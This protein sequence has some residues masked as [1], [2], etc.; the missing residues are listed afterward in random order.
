MRARLLQSNRSASRLSKE[1]KDGSNSGSGKKRTG[2][3]HAVRGEPILLVMDATER[4][5]YWEHRSER[6]D[7]QLSGLNHELEA[8]KKRLKELEAIQSQVSP[9]DQPHVQREIERTQREIRRSID[10]SA[11]LRTHLQVYDDKEPGE[12]TSAFRSIN[13]AIDN[14][15]RDMVEDMAKLRPDNKGPPV[16]TS[17]NVRDMLVVRQILYPQGLTNPSLIESSSVG[18]PDRE[19][20][21]F[22]LRFL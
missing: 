7:R 18:R 11:L 13:R 15:C 6:A 2:G 16:K 20:V 19:F 10:A 9:R 4:D 3:A 1:S 17:L 22:A 21:E 12:I 5:R 8:S 14:L